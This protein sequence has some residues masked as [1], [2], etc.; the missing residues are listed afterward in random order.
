[1]SRK[2]QYYPNPKETTMQYKTIIFELLQQRPA[3]HEQLRK[4][5]KLLPTM[6]KYAHELKTS[7]EAW[8]EMLLRMRPHSN[9]DQIASEAFELA[10][11]EMEDRLP[12]ASSPDGSE[13]QF[14][15]AA[16]LFLRR[17]MSRA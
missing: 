2:P 17:R 8:Q 16:M 7:H 6:E 14:L 15:D 1:L 3:M 10:L 4:D 12:S 5:R 13:P 11:K 9:R